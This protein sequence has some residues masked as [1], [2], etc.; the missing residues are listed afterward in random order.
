MTENILN[1]AKAYQLEY[2][3]DIYTDK[4]GV[5]CALGYADTQEVARAFARRGL[6]K[7]VSVEVDGKAK[8]LFPIETVLTLAFLSDRAERADEWKNLASDAVNDVLRYGFYIDPSLSAAPEIRI[9]IIEHVTRRNYIELARSRFKPDDKYL[10]SMLRGAY[11]TVELLKRP[12]S[13]LTAFEVKE[14]RALEAALILLQRTVELEP[15]HLLTA[16]NIRPMH[17]IREE[18]WARWSAFVEQHAAEVEHLA[19][20]IPVI[21]VRPDTP[22]DEPGIMNSHLPTL[23]DVASIEQLYLER[24]VKLN[25]PPIEVDRSYKPKKRGRAKKA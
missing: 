11:F 25:V 1:G 2:S 9:A 15:E 5:A 20:D 7:A 23:P 13:Y 17:P 24:G 8:R 3:D 22:D 4:Y 6:G 14:V 21:T 16:L 10:G 18:T 12:E 19:Q